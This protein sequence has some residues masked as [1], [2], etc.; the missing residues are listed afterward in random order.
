MEEKSNEDLEKNKYHWDW[1]DSN[2]RK[3]FSKFDKLASYENI[4]RSWL[5]NFIV[6]R[7]WFIYVCHIKVK[8]YQS[9]DSE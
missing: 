5:C 9:N 2:I 3:S 8:H 4:H 7:L 6:N 1:S